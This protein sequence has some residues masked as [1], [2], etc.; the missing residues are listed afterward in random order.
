MSYIS[1][2]L[3]SDPAELTLTEDA[4]SPNGSAPPELVRDAVGKRLNGVLAGN[5]RTHP[6]V[7]IPVSWYE[8]I[9]RDFRGRQ[10]P[11]LE[12]IHVLSYFVF[13]YRTTS[14]PGGLLW[15]QPGQLEELFGLSEGQRQSVL[16]Y[17]SKEGLLF[18]LLVQGFTPWYPEKYSK[19]GNYVFVAPIP[20]AINE[21]TH[22]VPHLVYPPK[23]K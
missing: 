11:Y 4:H 14:F 12:A 5:G 13:R 8:H 18:R 3:D 21:I 22:S 16:K 7:H 23:R 19:S 15:L 2:A 6:Y 10:R 1:A 9:T 17:L 20:E